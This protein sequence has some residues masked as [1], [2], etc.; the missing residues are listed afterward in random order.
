MA[1]SVG[2]LFRF[3]CRQRFAGWQSSRKTSAGRNGGG[4]IWKNFSELQGGHQRAIGFAEELNPSCLLGLTWTLT[5]N[6]WP[7]SYA[8]HQ[9]Y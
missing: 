2:G 7:R 4:L 3:V 8:G 5:S 6:L 9:L 1:A